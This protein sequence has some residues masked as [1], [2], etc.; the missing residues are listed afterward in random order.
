MLNFSVTY[1]YPAATVNL[2]VRLYWLA[3]PLTIGVLLLAIREWRRREVHWG[4]RVHYSAVAAAGVFFLW[5]LVSWNLLA[6][7]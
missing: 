7:L 2:I 5:F 6:G 3:I 4:G 1:V